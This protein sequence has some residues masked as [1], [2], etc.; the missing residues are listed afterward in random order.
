MI[1]QLAYLFTPPGGLLF[2]SFKN[3]V[4]DNLDRLSAINIDIEITPYQYDRNLHIKVM[5]EFL[6]T[7]E[8]DINKLYKKT[9]ERLDSV[10]QY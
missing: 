5:Q 6:K 8:T 9:I 2:A 7:K 3:F 4:R 10:I 1:R